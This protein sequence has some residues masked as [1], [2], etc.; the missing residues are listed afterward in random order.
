MNKTYITI[1]NFLIEERNIIGMELTDEYGTR[2]IEMS[3]L[4]AHRHLLELAK[5]IDSITSGEGKT[6]H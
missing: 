3:V 6:I 4:Q 1:A 5:A 2:I